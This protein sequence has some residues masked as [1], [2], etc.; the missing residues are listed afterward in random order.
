MKYTIVAPSFQADSGGRIALHYLCHLLN[1]AGHH[2]ELFPRG[3]VPLRRSS[4]PR[5]FA[6]LARYF[7]R[8]VKQREWRYATNFNWD[9]PVT[10]S[11]PSEETVVVY[12]EVVKGNPLGAKRV[13]RW[14]LHKPGHITGVAD[15]GENELYFF[16]QKAFNDPVINPNSENL[17][18][19]AWHRDDVYCRTNFG[20]RSGTC[21]MLRKGRGRPLVHDTRE[22]LLVDGLTHEELAQVFNEKKYFISYDPYTMY[23]R[24]AAMCGCTSI[25][26]PEEGV[27]KEQWRPEDEL[28]FG[29]AYGFDDIPWALETLPALESFIKRDKER[30]RELISD[31]IAKT[32]GFFTRR[33]VHTMSAKSIRRTS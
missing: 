14:F 28:R 10:W 7:A 3:R 16:Y 33:T 21:Y 2:A 25:V 24:F 17:L 29:I 23:S 31:F 19:I 27:S 26:I 12:P 30:Q 15:Y 5:D 18:R 11:P 1:E 32:E 13:V 8:R 6:I 22:S 9:T 20:A 4:G